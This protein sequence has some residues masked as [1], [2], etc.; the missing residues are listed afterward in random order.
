MQN[1]SIFSNRISK[2]S[3][4]KDSILKN[5]NNGSNYSV[6]GKVNFFS[7]NDI[8]YCLNGYYFQN[9]IKLKKKSKDKKNSKKPNLQI[10][11]FVG[12]IK[13]YQKISKNIKK[14]Q[15][16]SKNI[17]FL[18]IKSYKA[19]VKD[20]YLLSLAFNFLF[21]NSYFYEMY[22]YIH[23][24]LKKPENYLFLY[25]KPTNQQKAK[26]S[27]KGL[28]K[29]AY[30]SFFNNTEYFINT[31]Y[32]PFFSYLFF[33]KDISLINNFKN[34]ISSVILTK[35]IQLNEETQGITSNLETDKKP[36]LKKNKSYY[37]NKLKTIKTG[38]T[39][40]PLFFFSISQKPRGTQLMLLKI[41]FDTKFETESKNYIK[42][43]LSKNPEKIEFIYDL[44]ACCPNTEIFEILAFSDQELIFQSLLESFFQKKCESIE[45]FSLLKQ[46]ASAWLEANKDTETI[47]TFALRQKKIKK[48][49]KPG[50]FH[51][52]L[53]RQRD[54]EL[55]RFLYYYYVKK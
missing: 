1:I 40:R 23:N 41:I 39:V 46:E 43:I 16:I 4:S 36:Q 51:K 44:L 53:S 48:V 54:F 34:P 38:C 30:D 26:N 15:K 8:I 17:N 21:Y 5:T 19:A 52:N 31:L 2:I 10:N 28:N 42:T 7:V 18:K 33:K 9:F 6:Q 45:V 47:V 55:K 13:K 12:N 37:I 22:D 11:K 20:Q 27:F 25:K 32:S 3:C 35:I 24:K 50:S 29:I 49:V 14:Y